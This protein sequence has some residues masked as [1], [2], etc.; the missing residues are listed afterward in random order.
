MTDDSEHIPHVHVRDRATKG[1]EF[2]T[3]VKLDAPEY[4]IHGT[5]RDVFNSKQLEEFVA[6][7]NAKPRFSLEKTNWNHAVNE[8]NNNNDN[9]NVITDDGCLIPDYTRS[10]DKG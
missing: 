10:N 3:C 9:S 6:F 8:W 5:K 4:F 1:K 2:H 7:M